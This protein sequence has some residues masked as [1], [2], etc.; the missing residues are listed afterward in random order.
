MNLLTINKTIRAG[1]VNTKVKGPPKIKNTIIKII[2]I[3]KWAK[4]SLVKQSFSFLSFIICLKVLVW[5]LYFNV[6]PVVD[7]VFLLLLDLM[8]LQLVLYNYSNLVLKWSLY[9]RVW[10]GAK[11]DG[12]YWKWGCNGCT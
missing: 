7:M 2:D 4:H 12:P 8:E 1:I 11:C 9:I 3:D 10:T 5:I 6:L